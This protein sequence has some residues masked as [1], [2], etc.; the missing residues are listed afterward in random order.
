MSI[1]SKL[2]CRGGSVSKQLWLH[3]DPSPA[4]ISEVPTVDTVNYNTV[5]HYSTGIQYSTVTHYRKC[6]HYSTVLQYSTV[7]YRAEL[8]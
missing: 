2:V 7:Q 8:Y 4:R 3:R 6:I 5:I 1:P